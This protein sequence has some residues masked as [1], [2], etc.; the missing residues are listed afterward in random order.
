ML[1]A[2]F[3]LQYILVS[4]G[5]KRKSWRSFLFNQN[6]QK[7]HRDTSWIVSHVVNGKVPRTGDVMPQCCVYGCGPDRGNHL[8]AKQVRETLHT[9]C[10][11]DP[12]SPGRRP[13][14]ENHKVSMMTLLSLPL[15]LPLPL[16]LLMFIEAESCPCLPYCWTGAVRPVARPSLVHKNGSQRLQNLFFLLSCFRVI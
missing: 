4:L 9:L 15:F 3:R 1:L 6:Q 2:N 13:N 8:S 10:H 14:W 11:F 5:W 7:C 16:T 12:Q